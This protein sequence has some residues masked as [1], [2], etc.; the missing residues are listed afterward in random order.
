M[1]LLRTSVEDT[2]AVRATDV[3]AGG[4]R[5]Q[6][7]EPVQ[8]QIRSRE[9]MWLMVE[10]TATEGW[11]TV[12]EGYRVNTTPGKVAPLK[13]GQIEVV[14]HDGLRITL[15]PGP[16]QQKDFETYTRFAERLKE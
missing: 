5:P 12:N 9:E 4:I 14:V 1:L 16:D 13:P 15:D 2:H 3:A 8:M 11:I 10:G 6:R 7:G